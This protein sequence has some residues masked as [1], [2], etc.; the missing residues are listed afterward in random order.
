MRKENK[1]GT[2]SGIGCKRDPT[3]LNNEE[4][5]S[6]RGKNEADEKSSYILCAQHTPWL[7]SEWRIE[8][9]ELKCS[10][11]RKLI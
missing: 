9:N 4:A 1:P 3:E 2:N 8:T 5:K 11:R 7:L 6:I 10:E